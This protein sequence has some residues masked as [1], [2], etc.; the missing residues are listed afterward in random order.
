M[1]EKGYYFDKKVI[2]NYLLS[3]K[4]KPFVIFVGNS[5]TGKTK[6]SQLYAQYLM[7]NESNESSDIK[8][9]VRVGKAFSNGGWSV[10]PKDIQDLVPSDKYEGDLDLIVDGIPADGKLNLNTRIFFRS[11]DLYNHLKEL[12]DEDPNQKIDLVIKQDNDNGEFGGFNYKII[13]I[14]ANWTE[15]RHILGYYNVI[16]ESYQSTPT[17][18]LIKHAQKNKNDPFFLILDEMNMSHVERYFADFLSAIESGESIP[19]YS[20]ENNVYELDIP[21]N[22]LIVGTVN[23]D[24]TT[25]MFSPKVLDRANVLEFEALSVNDYMNFNFDNDYSFKDINYLLNPL[26]DI[27]V[28]N[29]SILDLM[30]EFN[31]VKNENNK[32]LWVV[33][34]NE[35]ELFQNVLKK[36]GFDF[37]FRVINE[38][39]KFMLVAWRYEGSPNVWDNWERYF[40]AQIKQKM[41]P[42]LHGSEKAIGYTIEELFNLC[43]VERNNNEQVKYYNLFEYSVRYPESAIK[44]QKMANSLSNQR[45]V[46]FIN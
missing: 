14:G 29:Y 35:L 38:I 30:N 20:D 23:V 39:L 5:G 25:Y 46:S 4:V 44:L 27:E 43:L 2:E 45:Y 11:D 22:L 8:T 36:V 6:L 3:L 13:P 19:L 17:F 16:T 18:D 9:R 41:L 34:S 37:G 26:N 21:K 42:K 24:E 33:L 12:H 1:V 32:N 31:G 15:N 10:S 40:D 7:K 28:R